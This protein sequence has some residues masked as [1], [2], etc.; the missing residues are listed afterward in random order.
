MLMRHKKTGGVYNV[1][2]L[3]IQESD[4]APVVVY[5]DATTGQIWTRPAA[6]FFDGRFEVDFPPKVA[7]DGGPLH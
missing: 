4:L 5:S 3:A 6:E 7:P 1:N 2:M